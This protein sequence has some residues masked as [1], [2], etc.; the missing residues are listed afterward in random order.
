MALG[1]LEG[2]QRTEHR[3]PALA[4]QVPMEADRGLLPV[5]LCRER[6]FPPSGGLE[7]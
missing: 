7:D 2:G 6:T 3:F 5:A 1:L 4:L